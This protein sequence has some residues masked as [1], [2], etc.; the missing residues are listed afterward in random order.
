MWIVT[1]TFMRSKPG[2]SLYSYLYPKLGKTL[3]LSYYLSF[4]LF[5][6]IREEEEGTGSDWKQEVVGGLGIRKRW[7][8]NIYTCK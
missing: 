2:I 4:L 8:S 5:N 7:H 6:I 3:C 1:H